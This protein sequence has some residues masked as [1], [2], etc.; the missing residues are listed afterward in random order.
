MYSIRRF[1]GEWNKLGRT[2]TIVVDGEEF[3]QAEENSG[4]WFLIRR[5]KE[6]E[7]EDEGEAKENIGC[8]QD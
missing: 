4:R 2:Y 6:G 3:I 5:E 7:E 8:I 1:A